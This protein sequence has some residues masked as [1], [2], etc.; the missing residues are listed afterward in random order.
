MTM[1]AKAALTTLA[2]LVAGGALAQTPDAV[3][4]QTGL[5]KLAGEPFI[6]N[7]KY[8]TTD[9]FL[10]RDV[11]TPFGVS[12]CYVHRD[13][14]SKLKRLAPI[15]QDKRLKLVMFDCYRPIEVQR[16]MWKLV[17]DTKYVADPA[18]GSQH[19]RGIA[20][21]VGLADEQGR[22]LPFP[23]AFDAFDRKAWAS[24]ACKTAEKVQCDNREMLKGLMHSVGIEGI[25]SEWW[26]FQLENAK[27]YPIVPLTAKGNRT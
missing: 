26:H 14:Y 24:Y 23:T 25:T 2:I 9:N 1:F 19:N 16:E 13:L 27:A 12:A 22:L 4:R 6:T 11:Y 20:I 10:H 17:P 18:R 3:E 15:L 5:R 21:D 8:A 7:L